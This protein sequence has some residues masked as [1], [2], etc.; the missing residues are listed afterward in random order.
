MNRDSIKR[1][2]LATSA[3]VIAREFVDMAFKYIEKVKE[4]VNR[5]GIERTILKEGS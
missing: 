1:T 2:W 3:A 4:K 5:I